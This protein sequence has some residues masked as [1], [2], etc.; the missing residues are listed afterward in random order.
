MNIT[1]RRRRNVYATTFASLIR[2]EDPCFI[3]FLSVQMDVKAPFMMNGQND[4]D[5]ALYFALDLE[6]LLRR[7]R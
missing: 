2:T 7:G 4:Q 3:S 1:V 6:L 5:Y